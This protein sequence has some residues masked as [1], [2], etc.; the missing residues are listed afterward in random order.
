MFH[1]A[2]DTCPD[3]LKELAA[4]LDAIAR[5]G[6]EVVNVTWQPGQPGIEDQAAALDARGSFL[7][8]SRVQGQPAVAHIGERGA[9]PL[10]A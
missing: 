6:A 4:L 10:T 3:D 2:I 1:H 8:I 5:G 9:R 7:I